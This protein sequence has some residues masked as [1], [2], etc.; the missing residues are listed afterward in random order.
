MSAPRVLISD[1]LSPAAVEI[2]RTN[3]IETVF[4]PALG[5]DKERLEKLIP[6]FDGLA[7]RSATKVTEKL[8]AKAGRLKIVGRAGIGGGA[9]R[10]QAGAVGMAQATGDAL[11]V[12][13]ILGQAVGLRI[14]QHL[15][16][17]FQ[18]AQET[19]GGNQP[20]T[21]VRIDLAAGHPCLQ[22]RQ[23]VADG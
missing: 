8:L 1:E 2:F 14:A 13:R 9:G 10:Q 7:I 12:Q 16:P 3:G 6:E 15:Q 17:V 11:A 4:E 18:H 20:L 19:V 22:R 23:C 5:R 21:G